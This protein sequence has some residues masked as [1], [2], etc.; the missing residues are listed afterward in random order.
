MNYNPKH[1]FTFV[2]N[3]TRSKNKIGPFI[4]K[5]GL[6]INEEP[7]I[8]LQKQ[9]ESVWSTPNKEFLIDD[10]DT[11]FDHEEDINYLV[12]IDFTG[13][14]ISKAIDKL[15][16][17]AAPGPDGIKPC[18]L[19]IFKHELI[20]PIQSVFKDSFEEGIF[21]NLWKGSENQAK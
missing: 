9:F 8:T 17:D 13:D 3:K 14:R 6:V 7:A 18:L 21:P 15:K 4:D 2:K 16:M 12:N 5:K 19:K 11:F 10:S 1:F 20:V